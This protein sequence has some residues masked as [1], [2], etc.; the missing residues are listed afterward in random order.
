MILSEMS[1]KNRKKKVM[2]AENSSVFASLRAHGAEK[3]GIIH[4]FVVS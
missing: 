4:S 3:S 1:R 2:G